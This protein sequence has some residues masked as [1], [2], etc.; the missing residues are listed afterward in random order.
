MLSTE[1]FSSG[2]RVVFIEYK[3]ANIF[4]RIGQRINK[5][6]RRLFKSNN[7]ID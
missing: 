2:S 7:N 6:L 1:E 3:R 5:F 4:E